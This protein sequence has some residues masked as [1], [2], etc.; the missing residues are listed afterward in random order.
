ML[1]SQPREKKGPA[2]FVSTGDRHL[3]PS[4]QKQQRLNQSLHFGSMH[5][6]ASVPAC[7]SRPFDLTGSLW[8]SPSLAPALRGHRLNKPPWEPSTHLPRQTSPGP[9]EVSSQGGGAMQPACRSEAG[10]RL[11]FPVDSDVQG[12][13]LDLGEGQTVLLR[14]LLHARHGAG[15]CTPPRGALRARSDVQRRPRGS[16][17]CAD[18]ASRW[19]HGD[20]GSGTPPQSQL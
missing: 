20:W 17:R 6:Q 4:F 1:R 3:G 8:V 16:E 12:T 19:Q 2:T 15:L 13:N 18:P 11:L 9:A 7:L 14:R 10:L 5:H